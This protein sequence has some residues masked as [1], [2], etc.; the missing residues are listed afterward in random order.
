MVQ[1]SPPLNVCVCVF[2]ELNTLGK[3]KRNRIPVNIFVSEHYAEGKGLTPQVSNG[4]DCFEML[5]AVIL[6]DEVVCQH[7]LSTHEPTQVR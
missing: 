5:T 3:P 2:Q 4:T 6:M 1:L 7:G